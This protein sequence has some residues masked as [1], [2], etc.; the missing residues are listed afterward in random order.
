M[1]SASTVSTSAEKLSLQDLYPPHGEETGLRRKDDG[2]GVNDLGINGFDISREIIAAGPIPPHGEETG[3][4]RKDD[5]GGV[6]DLGINGFDI[7]G[8]VVHAA[9]IQS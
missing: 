1:I 6:N 5:G 8:E 9:Q 3:L 7:S 2:G 4:R